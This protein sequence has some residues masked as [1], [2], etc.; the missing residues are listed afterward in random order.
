MNVGSLL[1]VFIFAL[2]LYLYLLLFSES[3]L[4]RVG[5]LKSSSLIYKIF[6]KKSTRLERILS[7]VITRAEEVGLPIPNTEIWQ[8][9]RF[10][11]GIFHDGW[12]TYPEYRI[13]ISPGPSRYSDDDLR[14]LI[15]HE[16]AHCIDYLIHCYKHPEFGYCID[17]RTPRKG[18]PVLERFTDLN[19]EEFADIISVYLYSKEMFFEASK[20]RNWSRMSYDLILRTEFT[21]KYKIIKSVE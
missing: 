20:R 18:H 2:V 21:T 15:A 5:R 3:I 16:F 7:E 11:I 6:M 10:F 8:V 4:L 19:V 17:M 13:L 14:M 12:A 9:R 1:W